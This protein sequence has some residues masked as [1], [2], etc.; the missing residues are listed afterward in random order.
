MTLVRAVLTDV[1]VA[2]LMAYVKKTE[3]GP[4]RID[5][6]EVSFTQAE[7]PAVVQTGSSIRLNGEAVAAR[8]LDVDELYATVMRKGSGT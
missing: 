3:Y 2:G 7:R 4:G 8:S 5:A 6:S 1:G